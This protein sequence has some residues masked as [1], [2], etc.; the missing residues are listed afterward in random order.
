MVCFNSLH[1]NRELT[2]IPTGA[3]SVFMHV[4]DMVTLIDHTTITTLLEFVEG[5]KQSGRGI[6]TIVGLD[7]LHA[8]SH[9]GAAMRISQP[10]LAKDRAEAM[11][12]LARIGLLG[13]GE[14]VP[15]SVAFLERMSLTHPGPIEGNSDHVV[16]RAVIDASRYLARK[17]KATLTAVR[18]MGVGD[19][20]VKESPDHDLEWLSL[21]DLKRK[22]G[23]P[24]DLAW[25]CL[26]NAGNK[27]DTPAEAMARLSLTK[28]KPEKASSKLDPANL[29]HPAIPAIPATPAPAEEKKEEKMETSFD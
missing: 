1:L 9:S 10:V 24:P 4:T 29:S 20:E 6:A 13:G 21:G 8:R 28:V 18:T 12:E 19:G 25:F 26:K 15:S 2:A 17:C 16:T 14:E 27:A 5:F 3:T 22:P 23:S 11:T 7:K